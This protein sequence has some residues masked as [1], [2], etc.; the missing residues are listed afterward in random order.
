[1]A[2]EAWQPGRL[3]QPGDLV[4]PRSGAPVVTTALP[5]PSFESDLTGWSFAYTG[6]TP[7][8]GNGPTIQ[9]EYVFAGT[10][11]VRYKG[12]A[13]S[14]EGGSI[15]VV[16]RNDQLF[17]VRA[18]QSVGMQLRT[19][20]N[21]GGGSYCRVQPRIYWLNGSEEDIQYSGGEI[22]DGKR[23]SGWRTGGVT[24]VAPAG[25][26]YA[27]VAVWVTG[28]GNGFTDL[29]DFSI[30]YA[31]AGTPAGLIY[32][33]TQAE[34]GFSGAA[35]P[36][37]PAVVG[38]TVYDNEVVWEGVLTS[39]VVWEAAPILV[40]GNTEPD[41][42]EDAG[43]YVADNTIA[44]RAL[45]RR[46]EDA[47]CPHSKVVAIAASKVFAGDDDIVAYC[48][49]VNPL[50]WSS[51]NDAGYLP[52]GLQTYGANP[53]AAL[54]LYRSNLV[55]SN[56]TGYQMWQVDPNPANM[57]LL[58]AQ[59]VPF[60][61][62]KSLQPAANDLV[63]LTELGIRS[64]G[65]AGASTNLQ[66]GF[67]GKNVDPLV[68]PLLKAAKLAGYEPF[69][70]LWPGAGQY[71]C[72]FGTQAIVLT[73]N[74]PSE[75]DM[76]WSRYVFPAELT[77]WTIDG[78]SL[79]L[80][81]GDLVWEVSEDA[82]TAIGGPM[83]DIHGDVGPPVLELTDVSSTTLTFEWTVPDSEEPIA[84][85][86]VY[87]AL[88]TALLADQPGTTYQITPYEDG[89]LYC[90]YV[91][92]YDVL[93]TSSVPSNTVCYGLPGPPVLSIDSYSAADGIAL[94]WTEPDSGNP[95]AG[96]MLFDAQSNTLLAT[97]T[98]RTFVYEPA[99]PGVP[100]S[101]Y[102]QAYDDLDNVSDP[103][104][105]VE[106]TIY[107][108]ITDMQFNGSF[109]DSAPVPVA[110]TLG[111]PTPPTD[112]PNILGNACNFRE[113]TGWF[114][115]GPR[116]IVYSDLLSGFDLDASSW[117]LSFKANNKRDVNLG[118][119]GQPVAVCIGK[120]GT[121]NLVVAM[122]HATGPMSVY[123]QRT[124]PLDSGNI[125]GLGSISPETYYTVTVT[126]DKALQKLSY[127]LGE[128]LQG[129]VTGRMPGGNQQLA[130]GYLGTWADAGQA[131]LRWRGRLD[132]V[133]FIAGAVV[134]P[135][136]PDLGPTAPSEAGY[137]F[138]ARDNVYFDTSPNTWQQL[139][140]SVADPADGT[141]RLMVLWFEPRLSSPGL[142]QL[143][144][145]NAS[146][147]PTGIDDR[148][149]PTAALNTLAVVLGA[150]ATG[151]VTI[152]S[153]AFISYRYVTGASAGRTGVKRI[154]LGTFAVTHT[155]ESTVSTDDFYRLCSDGTK[156]WVVTTAASLKE[157]STTNLSVLSTTSVGASGLSYATTDGTTIWALAGGTALAKIT[158]AGGART[159]YSFTGG[160]SGPVDL[161][162]YAGDVY[163]L[164]SNFDGEAETRRYDGAT[165]ARDGTFSVSNFGETFQGRTPYITVDGDFMGLAQRPGYKPP[166]ESRGPGAV[167]VVDFSGTDPV[168]Y[169]H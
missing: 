15:E 73:I 113:D 110:Y 141:K 39:R 14:G 65:I 120:D 89:Q 81:A 54:G 108:V 38:E 69:G 55:A 165:G 119:F 36:V 9:T 138:V 45:S 134:P 93:G 79:F 95:I 46:I 123:F 157:L 8:V 32:R 59:P 92:A 143:R 28:N 11:A 3:Y 87:D 5:N 66:A 56:N 85:Y 19:A 50:D 75:K 49:T 52:F 72:V 144:R 25:A 43:A 42:P 30:D 58:D 147:N 167:K 162:Y 16:L 121:N 105:V 6:G 35:E 132:D 146:A 40:S 98:G 111:P 37:W 77:D 41:F 67:F 128:T 159:N 97:Q 70:I 33:A 27:Q 18:G 126:Y 151:F 62:H 61:H 13:G 86:R 60:N 161:A 44:W 7:I 136:P 88:T 133:K 169:Q 150:Y 102:V 31:F 129:E 53:V 109:D 164:F 112:Q 155:F 145:Y 17:P 57:A 74:G 34:A 84:G 168:I 153:A 122:D 51:P 2:T 140:Y 101:F 104:N 117:T 154:D 83:D 22:I 156:V 106:V 158:I 135:I 152:G 78:T 21:T 107:D 100:Y 82:N 137:L 103:S 4:R 90:L 130:M 131:V 91:V 124:S 96:Y 12:G 118:G 139:Q 149:I 125:I 10:K 76:S 68:L 142:L 29:D 160:D 26:V 1:M 99:Y 63:G 64:I 116:S 148:E 115:G 94:S 127:Y 48:S 24:D 166:G 80:R 163:I 23:P 20:L 71:W 47:K 114:N